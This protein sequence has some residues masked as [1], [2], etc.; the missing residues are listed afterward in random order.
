AAAAPGSWLPALGLGALA[1]LLA[2]GM[3][4][5]LAALPSPARLA[6]APHA[7]PAET[8][9]GAQ[10]IGLPDEVRFDGEGALLDAHAEQ[11]VPAAGAAGAAVPAELYLRSGFFE[12]PGLDRWRIDRIR[13]EH[14]ATDRQPLQLRAPGP[15][16]LRLVLQFAPA[17]RELMF[18]PPDLCSIEGIADLAAEPRREWFHRR[19]GDAGCA[20]VRCRLPPPAVDATLAPGWVGGADDL[21]R[22]PDVLDRAPFERL[23]AEWRPS[24]GPIAIARAVAAGLQARCHYERREPRGPYAEPLRNFL[25]GDR[26]GFCMH[27]ASAAAILLRLCSVPC[28]V[29]VG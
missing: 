5:A 6:P 12:L 7:P 11:L 8:G 9:G 29:A 20:V 13:G 14:F 17:A 22:L 16:A 23:L 27:F 1:A 24:G 15:D 2:A 28:R 25:D 3:Q 4:L 19:S 18:V 21:T 26:A 10:R